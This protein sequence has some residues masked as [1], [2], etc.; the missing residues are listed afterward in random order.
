MLYFSM[1]VAHQ[2]HQLL[3]NKR[4]ETFGG[5]FEFALS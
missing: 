1:L 4:T 5:G 3:V 2:A